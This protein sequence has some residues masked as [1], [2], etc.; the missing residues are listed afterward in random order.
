[1]T[2]KGADYVVVNSPAAMAT[3]ESQACILSRDGVALPWARRAK[4]DLA[5]GIL[6]LLA[7]Q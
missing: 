5:R 3:E 1:M 6:K 4:T 7:G 2:A